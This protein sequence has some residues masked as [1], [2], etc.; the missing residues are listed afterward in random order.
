[1][2]EIR[3]SMT[4]QAIDRLVVIRKVVEKELKQYEA[5]EGLGLSVRQLKRLVQRYRQEGVE[6]ICR[7][8]QG[9]NRAFMPEKKAQILQLLRQ[10]YADFGPSFAAEKL[11]EQHGI[12]VSR[13]TLRYWMMEAT[14]WKGKHR[15]K[16]RI[17]QSRARRTRFGELIQLDGSPHDWF[18][19]RA[20]S[21]CLLVLIDDAT[22]KLVGLRFEPSETTLGYFRVI[23]D[24]LRTYGRPRAWYSDKDSIFVTS[25]ANQK[26]GLKEQTQFQRAMHALDIQMIQANSPEAK[27]RVERANQTL[28][29]RLIKEMRLRGI[30]SIEEANGFLPAFIQGYNA[31]FGVTAACQEDAHRALTETQSHTLGHILSIQETRKLSKQLECRY[32]NHLYQIKRPGS[33]YSFRHANITVCERTDGKIVL[34]KDGKELAYTVMV[35][36]RHGAL[37]AESKEV[38]AVLNQL[39]AEGS[40]GHGYVDKSPSNIGATTYPHTHTPPPVT[41]HAA[42]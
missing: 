28:Q 40:A 3:I 20:P 26:D 10:H 22:S 16:A 11:Q 41:I 36:A 4:S 30:C 19:G 13:E 21:C 17:H 33:G 2:Q 9:G 29:D 6:G 31:K 39:L 42:A 14:L 38:N 1:M 35:K 23:E 24:Y 18:E 32:R 7:R 37:V 8:K 12:K 25:R 27:G 5:A 15:K 34:V